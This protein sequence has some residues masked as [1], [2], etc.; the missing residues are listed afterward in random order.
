MLDGAAVTV[1]TAPALVAVEFPLR[2]ALGRSLLIAGAARAALAMSVRYET[3]RVQF[4]RPIAKLQAIQQTLALAGAEVAAAEAAAAEALHL[5]S[6]VGEARGCCRSRVRRAH[7]LITL[8]RADEATAEAHRALAEAG[9]R[10]GL[11][12]LA[13]VT[14][15]RAL[16]R[17]KP[18]EAAR[19]CERVLQLSAGRPAFS[20]VARF[21][22]ALA[23]HGHGHP[24]VGDALAAIEAWGDRRVLAYCLADV[25][26]FG[27]RLAI[28]FPTAPRPPVAWVSEPAC[29][30][31][32]SCV[33]EP[34][35]DPTAAAL[36]DA[37]HAMAGDGPWADR[38]AGAARALVRIVPWCRAAC[39]GDV[40]LELRWDRE[41][42][43]PLGDDDLARVLAPRATSVVAVDL[44]AE[45]ELKTHPTRA[46]FGLGTALMAPMGEDVL[47]FDLREDKGAPSARQLG[48]VAELAR[49]LSCFPADA[50][51]V[52]D[53]KESV[54]IPGLIGRSAAMQELQRQLGRLA[55]FD[56]TVHIC[57][58]TGTGKEKA[59]QALHERSARAKKPFVAVNA[60]S[61]ADELFESEMFG[62]L[63]GSFTGAVADREGHV[64]A[65]EG[66]TLF[67]DEIT[68]LSA[69]GQAKLLR[70]LEVKEYRRVGES[71]TRRADVRFITAS[72][73]A[74]EERVAQG[75]FRED[76][77][78][79]LNRAVLSVPPLRERSGD[80]LLL[81]RHFLRGAAARAGVATPILSAEAARAL[82]RHVWPGNVRELENE[83]DRLIVMCGAATIRRDDLARAIVAPPSPASRSLR[84]ALWAFE[85][86]YITRALREHGGNRARTACLLGLTRQALVAKIARLGIASAARTSTV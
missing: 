39:V 31:A 81:A 45:N 3:E 40:A 20:G 22:R 10:D 67:L 15:A 83:M 61:L 51:T 23:L 34:A 71:R 2:A 76:L 47:Y 79:R 52:G 75:R 58:E 14:L 57:G 28:G 18:A 8:R 6:L 26:Q 72:N 53:V 9:Q 49:L 37:A 16:L 86:D 1:G 35:S 32:P 74:L 85:R 59:A 46:L 60:S 11:R 77:M 21:G 13:G 36:V 63:R 38:W 42:P 12:A 68:D 64:A 41:H 4:G 30:V 56:V 19:A 84:E 70:L 33:I 5:F 62:H 65:A 44:L 80:V 25:R 66:G 82:E 7:A 43:S 55:R 78:Y 50:A 27:G 48:A 29:V 24:E 54:A 69:R 17:R 73:V